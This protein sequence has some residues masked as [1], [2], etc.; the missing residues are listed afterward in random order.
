MRRWGQ[1]PDAKPAAWYANTIKDIYRP[2]IWKKAATLLVEEGY[3]PSTDIPTTDGF[4]PA[5]ADFIDGTKYD[6]KDPL[7]YI[8]SFKIGNKDK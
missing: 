7:G 2:D 3:I 5:T 1:I 6:A 8:N 4:K